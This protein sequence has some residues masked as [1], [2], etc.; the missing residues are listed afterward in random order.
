MG[1]ESSLKLGKESEECIK[2]LE[3]SLDKSGGAGN[4]EKLEKVTNIITK[5]IGSIEEY[6]LEECVNLETYLK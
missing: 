1:F 3:K 2:L 6:G 5:S 4:L